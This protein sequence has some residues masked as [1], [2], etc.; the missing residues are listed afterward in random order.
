[1]RMGKLIMLALLAGGG[2]F[3]Y[4]KF[5]YKSPALL[6]YSAYSEAFRYGKC[7]QLKAMVEEKAAAEVEEFC[8][9]PT[10]MGRQMPSA[11]GMANDMA[12]TPSGAMMRIS[13][14]AESETKDSGGEVTLKVVEKAGT[15]GPRDPALDTRPKRFT[16]RLRESGG[17]WKIL[18]VQDPDAPPKPSEN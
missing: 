5:L 1:M 18:E 14:T 13:R 6:A 9:T 10:F 16:V 7:D 15:L 11:A 17:S 2:W 12:N 8:A 4:Q 3:A